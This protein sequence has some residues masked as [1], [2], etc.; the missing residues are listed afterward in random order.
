MQG[1]LPTCQQ[2]SNVFSIIIV[3]S[4]FVS[5]IS[6]VRIFKD[7]DEIFHISR[8]KCS[9]DIVKISAFFWRAFASYNFFKI[10]THLMGI[11]LFLN[12]RN[13]YANKK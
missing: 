7:F 1:M 2:S 6:R 12:C 8:S 5:S 11:L 10:G 13:T 4:A 9:L 3:A